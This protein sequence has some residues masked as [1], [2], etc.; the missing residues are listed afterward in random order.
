MDSSHSLENPCRQR[1]DKAKNPDCGK[2]YKDADGCPPNY[3]QRVM[4]SAVDPGKGPYDGEEEEQSARFT[5]AEPGP[6]GEGEGGSRGI[7]GERGIGAGIKE[8]VDG[9]GVSLK[10][11]EAI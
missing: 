8:E 11:S 6:R 7:R 3:V 9:I 1:L 2:G 5:I 4:Y 10:W